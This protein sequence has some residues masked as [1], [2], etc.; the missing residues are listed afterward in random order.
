M[1]D[2]SLSTANGYPYN[3]PVSFQFHVEVKGITGT[4]ECLFQ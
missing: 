3:I 1:V 4:G 2:A